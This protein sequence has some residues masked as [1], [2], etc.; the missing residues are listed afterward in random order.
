MLVVSLRPRGA[1]AP[2][3]HRF[4]AVVSCVGPGHRSVVSSSPVLRSLHQDG[5]LGADP[6]ALGIA[7]DRH[8][9]VLGADG[10]P[11]PRVFVAG[12]LARGQH[13]ELMGLPQVS[14]QPREVAASL[15]RLLGDAEQQEARPKALPLDSAQG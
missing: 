2:A 6:L 3:E 1:A 10:V 15:A 13:G 9:R 11:N 8:N 12:P 7:V 5:V 4:G 14:T